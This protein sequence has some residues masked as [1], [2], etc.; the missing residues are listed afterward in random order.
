MP[1]CKG[2]ATKY[3]DTGGPAGYCSTSCKR[4]GGR[5]TFDPA[6]AKAS[7]GLSITIETVTID[8]FTPSGNRA[9]ENLQRATVGLP[10]NPAT[11]RPHSTQPKITLGP[12]VCECEECEGVFNRGKGIDDRYCSPTCAREGGQ[13]QA[14]NQREQAKCAECG[15]FAPIWGRERGAPFCAAQC[16]IAYRR[17]HYPRATAPAPQTAAQVAAKHATAPKVASGPAPS[18]R[19]LAARSAMR[20]CLHCGQGSAKPYCSAECQAAGKLHGYDEALREL[21]Q[22][23]S[24]GTSEHS[25]RAHRVSGG[26]PTLVLYLLR[27][28][29]R[30]TATPR[31][32]WQPGRY[33][34]G[35]LMSFFPCSP[36]DAQI[37]TSSADVVKAIAAARK[38]TGLVPE[39]VTLVEETMNGA[40]AKVPDNLWG[41]ELFAELERQG[42]IDHDPPPPPAPTKCPSCG[43]YYT[44]NPCGCPTC[45]PP[46]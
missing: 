19:E 6:R 4:T 21:D 38:V 29:V 18:M 7:G 9:I 12:D 25:Q 10:P 15:K 13:P 8:D 27:I 40:K 37:Y 2:C 24:A 11:L 39:I 32:V 44:L 23:P 1:V 43:T 36:Q 5:P 34:S 3:V 14:I 26:G 22:P 41:D 42:L 30:S 20:C 45:N 46:D 28:G 16:A 33:L 31:N 17:K 35:E